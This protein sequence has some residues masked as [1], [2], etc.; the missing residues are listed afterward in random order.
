MST[1][2]ALVVT[3]VGALSAALSPLWAQVSD[4]NDVVSTWVP[5]GSATA[6]VAGLVFMARK[7]ASGELVPVN[8]AEVLASQKR[9]Q[10]ALV[11]VAEEAGARER[12][13]LD[14]VKNNTEAMVELRSALHRAPPRRATAATKKK[15]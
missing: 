1:A 7:M 10:D 12:V 6:A 3:G 5:A 9:T 8:I 4:G 2:V 11:K 14:L 13:L 15:S